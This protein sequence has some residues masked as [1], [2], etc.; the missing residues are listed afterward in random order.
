VGIG[1]AL[2]D[3]LETDARGGGFD[4]LVLS[5]VAE[6][7]GARAFWR[8]R[9]YERLRDCSVSGSDSVWFGTDL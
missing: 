7:S 6:M 5:S 4:N 8:R 3:R 9:G 2:V 1:S